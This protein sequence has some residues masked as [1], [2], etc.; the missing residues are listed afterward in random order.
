LERQPDGSLLQAGDHPAPVAHLGIDE[1]RRGRPADSWMRAPAN[2]LSWR[3]GGDCTFNGS[4][5][6]SVV[7]VGD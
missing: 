1:H 3:T 6:L 2:T 7:T 4:A 5:A